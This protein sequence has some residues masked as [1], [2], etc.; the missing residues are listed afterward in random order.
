MKNTDLSA[1]REKTKKVTTESPAGVVR[2]PV[3]Y[4]R[5][6]DGTVFPVEILGRFFTWNGRPVHIAAIRDITEKN[7]TEAAIREANRK[8]NLLNSITRHDIRNQLTVAQ[9]YTQLAALSK[10]DPVIMDFLAKITAA[11]ETI[12]R[13]IEFTKAYQELGVHA[14]SWFRLVD[15]VSRARPEKTAV[16]ITCKVVEIFADPMID[17]VFFN[18]FDNALKYGETVTTVTVGCGKRE[19]S[20]VITFADNGTG[21]APGDKQKIFEKGYGKNTGLGLFLVRGIR[22][23][24]DITISETGTPGEGAVFEIVV[25]EG[26]YRNAE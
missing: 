26:A 12:Q 15:I 8:L 25:P 7:Q 4:H 5:R 6:K 22:A 14:P 2:V 11:I 19:N 20:L 18:L 23:I 24:T 17:M 13:Q 1:E 16:H 9:G 3:R 21:I 10:P